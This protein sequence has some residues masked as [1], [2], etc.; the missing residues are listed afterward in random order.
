M[1]MKRFAFLCAV[2]G[3]SLTTAV[4]AAAQRR[5]TI[6]FFDAAYRIGLD[7]SIEV[8]ERVTVRFE[9][10]WNGIYRWVPVKY[11]L[12]DGRSH[13][14][15]LDVTS[16]ADGQGNELRHEVK[17]QGALVKIKTWVPGAQDAQRTI[18]YRYRVENG[19]RYFDGDED[20]EWAHD[21]FY[22]NVTGDE[23]EMP[24]LRAQAT[25]YLPEGVTGT[26]TIAYTG[27]YGSRGDDYEQIVQGNRAIFETN[28]RLNMR[29]GFTIVVGWDPGVVARPTAT[30]RLFWAM[31][32]YLFV[33]L[34]I[35]AF[36][37]MFQL[38]WKKG[39]DPELNR[40]IM[41]QYEPPENMSPAQIGTLMDFSVDPRDVSATI[42]DL[43]VRGYLR[44]EEVPGRRPSRPKDHII[45]VLKD[46]AGVTDLKP[47]ELEALKGLWDLAEVEEGADTYSVKVSD[48]KQEYYRT[49]EKIKK[50]I[51]KSLTSQPK[52]FTAKPANVQ[53]AWFGIAVVVAALCVG[54]GIIARNMYLGHPVVSWVSLA[55]IP[56]FVF[57]FGMVMPARTLKGAWMLNLRD[58]A[59]LRGSD[60]PGGEVDRGVRVAAQPAARLV[61]E[62]P[63]RWLPRRLFLQLAGPHGDDDRRRRGDGAP[64]IQ[65]RL[66][67]Q[68]WRRLLGWRVRRRRWRRVLG[69]ELGR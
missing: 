27:G 36:F 32:Q 64:L 66:G 16:V 19:L 29:E 41:P 57:G 48:L 58:A 47:H 44:I 30:K 5:L 7:G 2:I 38:W 11:R 1:K 4:P 60:G 35:I 40:S 34:P 59:P 13:Q 46:P 21:E 23:W 67:V 22:W 18:V 53:A 9:G 26:R 31:L 25:V 56:V 12:D 42:I 68:R 17:R 50:H 14:V 24:I 3:L 69:W 54:A 55:A 15:H 45:H 62:P 6:V 8:E 39:R 63:S 28:R 49:V 20:M 43:A 10:S 33:P 37:L 51:F 65:R 61:R 52:L